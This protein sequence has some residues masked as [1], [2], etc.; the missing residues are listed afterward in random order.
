MLPLHLCHSSRITGVA[1]LPQQHVVEPPQRIVAVTCHS[2]RLT[3]IVFLPQ[4]PRR[5][6]CVVAAALW[7]QQCCCHHA[8]ALSRIAATAATLPPSR[9]VAYC[10]SK[11]EAT[12][13]R[14]Y[15]L[16][17]MEGSYLL[18]G[19]KEKP[20]SS[21][22]GREELVFSQILSPLLIFFKPM[23]KYSLG[24]HFFIQKPP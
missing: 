4:Q 21:G 16:G 18:P 22:R 10:K 20:N 1:S 9:L 23:K 3:A 7:P 17:K 14:R 8:G 5:C 13:V 6:R 19:T 11:E 12:R 24:P 2:S 15:R